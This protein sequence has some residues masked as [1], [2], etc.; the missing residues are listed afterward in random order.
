MTT[1]IHFQDVPH[2]AEVRDAFERL[3]GDLE[4]AFPETDRFEVTLSHA[5]DV[6][7]A[8]LHVTGKNLSVNASS[9]D[10]EPQLA[11][12]DAF[13]KAH[14]QLRKRHDKTIFAR[15]REAQ[16]GRH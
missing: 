2:D 10:R 13:Q 5:G 15:R 6:Y 3:S 9:D 1:R 8:H 14:A 11:L 16:K 12:G 7:R 4:Q